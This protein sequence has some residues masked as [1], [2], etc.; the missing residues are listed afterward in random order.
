[1][2]GLDSEGRVANY[3]ETEQ[4]VEHD[5]I[6]CSFVQTRGSVPMYWSQRPNL[7]YKPDPLISSNLNHMDGFQRHFAEQIYNY[8]Q[9]ILINLLDQKGKEDLLVKGYGRIVENAGNSNIRH[10]PFDFHHECRKM[11]WDRLSILTDR[12]EA[13][14]QKFSFFSLNRD[15]SVY[16][17]QEGVFRTNCIDCLDRTNVVQSLLA[18]RSLQ[19]QLLRL[20]ILNVGERIEDQVG[21]EYVFKNVW[22]DNA[23]ACARQYAGTGALKTDFTRHGKR[24]VW[25]ALQDGYNCLIR[26]H[27]NNFYDGFRQ[28]SLDLFIGNYIVEEDE[29]ITKKSPLR[30]DKDWKFYALP[31]VFIVAFSMCIISILIPDEHPSEQ[32]MYIL[33]WGSASAASLSLIYLFGKDFVDKPKLSQGRPKMD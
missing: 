26:Y 9:Q 19:D 23:D 5:G 28:D 6:K 27:M 29:G 13:D 33:F 22:A 17:L 1:M 31:T 30:T 24:S 16:S 21:F 32:I 4:I 10:E 20:D 3:V 25:G 7:K 11:R 15:G 12:V 14:R 2:R 18:R 8:G